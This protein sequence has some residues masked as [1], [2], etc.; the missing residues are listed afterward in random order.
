MA[1]IQLK[2]A[3]SAAIGGRDPGVSADIRDNAAVLTL[4]DRGMICDCNR[5]GEALFKYRRSEMV[6]QHVSMLLPQLADMELVRN[7][8]PNSGLRYLSRIGHRFQAVAR[9]GNS[10]ATELYLNLLDK[11][12]GSRL[13]LIARRVAAVATSDDGEVDAGPGEA[14][15]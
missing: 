10:F 14:H 1:A 11:Q 7:G 13:S 9:D 8:A 3:A 15:G 6:W 12:R 4:N 2:S 5:S